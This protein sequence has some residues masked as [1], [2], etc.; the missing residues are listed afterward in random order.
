MP[1]ARDIMRRFPRRPEAAGAATK[2]RAFRETFGTPLHNVERVWFLLDQ[3]ELQPPNRRPKHLLWVLHFLKMNLL[4]A[5]GCA[6]DGVSGRAFDPK[7]HQ[8]WV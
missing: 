6:A 5:P 3:K 1:A 4:Q 8:K 2:A 7:T